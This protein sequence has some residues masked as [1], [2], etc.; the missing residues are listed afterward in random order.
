[1]DVNDLKGL[2]AESKKRM[3]GQIEHV[4][5]ELAG[6]RTGRASTGLLENVHGRG[7]R[8]QDAAQPG[9]HAVDSRAV[10]DRRAALR[11]VDDGQRR[12]GDPLVGPRPE[13]GQRRQG[14]PHPDPGAH[15]RAPQGAVAARPQGRRRGPQPRPH[16]A[17]RRQRPAEEDAQGSRRSPKTTRSAASTRCRGSPIRRSRRSTICRRRRTKSCS[18]SSRGSGPGAQCSVT[19]CADQRS[20]GTRAPRPESRCIS[21]HLECSQ[22]LRRRALRCPRAAHVCPSC[23]MPLFAR[24]DLAQARA[25]SR[26]SPRRPSADDVAL[27]RDAAALRRR[28]AGHAR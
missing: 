15:R 3:D 22:P 10:A 27:P 24:Y 12:E 17:A 6:V 26:D 20:P 21:T 1:M 13:S 14:G 28:D 7:L 4:R 8:R 16:R 11:P 19:A 2:F 25:W 23:G 9:R 5:R 18:A